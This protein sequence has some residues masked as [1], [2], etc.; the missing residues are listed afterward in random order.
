MYVVTFTI[1]RLAI[2]ILGLSQEPLSS[3]YQMIGNVRNAA[4]RKLILNPMMHLS[5]DK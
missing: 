2:L 3:H 4:Q 1:L 5:L